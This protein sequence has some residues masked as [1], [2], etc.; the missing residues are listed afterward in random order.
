[1]VRML[2]ETFNEPVPFVTRLLMTVDVLVRI[3][4]VELMIT[5][6][7]SVGMVPQLQLAEFVQLFELAPVKEQVAALAS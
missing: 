5:S 6:S 4:E 7:L 1:M 3:V 2:L